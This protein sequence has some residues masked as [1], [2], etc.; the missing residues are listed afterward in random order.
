MT[1]PTEKALE[2]F[3][4]GLSPN[5]IGGEYP[6]KVERLTG[7][8]VRAIRAAL[9]AAQG[10]GVARKKLAIMAKVCEHVAGT[11]SDAPI[12]AQSFVDF[13]NAQKARLEEALQ[14]LSPAT[15]EAE[16]SDAVLPC[17]VRVGIGTYHKGV[18]VSALQAAIDRLYTRYE[19]A[20]V[21]A[22]AQEAREW[23][24]Q[25]IAEI[26]ID[27][28]DGQSS[29]EQYEDIARALA[30]KGVI[31]TKPKDGWKWVQIPVTEDPWHDEPTPSEEKLLKVIRKIANNPDCESASCGIACKKA[32]AAHSAECE[33]GE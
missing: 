20:T 26:C 13:L 21:E 28:E 25:E 3:E 23:T 30:A 12:D 19:A 11:V 24:V 18:N 14:S 17:A 5:P 31:R 4:A 9:K 32:L 22:P 2:A 16:L 8:E 1:T 10:V 7:D 33:K 15:V 6:Y 27:T 29:S